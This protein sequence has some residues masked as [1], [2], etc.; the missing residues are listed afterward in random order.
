MNKIWFFK[1]ERASTI[2]IV[3][4]NFLQFTTP[5]GNIWCVCTIYRHLHDTKPD[6][7]SISWK[8]NIWWLRDEKTSGSVFESGLL[9]HPGKLLECSPLLVPSEMA[10]L[11]SSPGKISL[12][13]VWI[14]LLEIVAFLLYLA[15][16]EASVAIL[17]KISLMKESM[18]VGNGRRKEERW[19][20]GRERQEE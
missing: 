9:L 12:T 13:A 17:S 18:T 7:P 5:Q 14:S 10:C 8:K 15:S 20:A 6:Y 2:P 3:P 4:S 16:L 11:L 1:R 19:G